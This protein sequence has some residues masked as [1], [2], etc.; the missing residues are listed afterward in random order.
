MPAFRARRHHRRALR[1]WRAGHRTAALAAAETAVGLCAGPERPAALITLGDLR[2]QLG[3]HAGAAAAFRAAGPA[4]R[5]ALGNCLRLLGRFA[6]A[7]AALSAAP[8]GP[9]TRNALGALCKDT[10]RYAEAAGH[11][12]AALADPALRGAVHHNLAGLA[13]A[14]GR[15]TDA[16][17]AARTALVWHARARG[18]G[19]PEVAADAAVL[20]A[21]LHALGRPADAAAALRRAGDI[22]QGRYGPE[23]HEARHCRRALAVVVAQAA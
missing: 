23:H 15:Y 18:A 10:G 13:H 17:V 16:L 4:G 20:G 19:S 8:P 6:E 5:V 11:Y 22:W 9:A 14:E 1:L 21:V 2:F 3:R 7:E 12:A